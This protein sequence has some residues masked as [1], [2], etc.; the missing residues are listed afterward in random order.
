MR[1]LRGTE[2]CNG[3]DILPHVLCLAA[4]VPVLRTVIAGKDFFGHSALGAC[5]CYAAAAKKCLRSDLL[6]E[7]SLPSA[8]VLYEWRRDWPLGPE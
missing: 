6:P 7:L 5:W 1:P 2:N 8:G 3:P 4:V